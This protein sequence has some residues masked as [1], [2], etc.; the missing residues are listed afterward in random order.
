MSR[1]VMLKEEGLVVQGSIWWSPGSVLLQ[2][3]L[4]IIPTMSGLGGY[5][6]FL[7]GAS[8]SNFSFDLVFWLNF[9]LFV[10]LERFFNWGLSCLR[11]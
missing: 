11:D 1:L 6:F 7:Y 9:S 4:Q 8:L 3:H 2:P 5:S 10:L